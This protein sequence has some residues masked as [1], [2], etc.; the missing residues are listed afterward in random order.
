MPPSLVQ[1]L[2]R[3]MGRGAVLAS[4]EDLLVYECD[5]LS[6]FRERAEAIVFPRSTEEVSRIVTLCAE[7]SVP[8]VPRGA[9]TGLSGGATPVAGGVVVELARMNQILRVVEEDRC[10][11]VECGV[12]NA[13]LSAAVRPHGLLYAPDPSSQFACTIGGNVAENSGGPH[14][15]KYGQTAR[16]VLGLTLVLCDGS[17]V[18]AGGPDGD[19]PGYDLAGAFTGSEGTFGIATEAWV[20]LEPIPP[21]VETFLASFRSIV[22]A[23][24]AVSGIVAEGIVP[25]ALEMLDERTIAA[26]E[27]SVYAA[28][29]PREAAAV[30]LVELDGAAE[31]VH[32]DAQI[33]RAVCRRCGAIDLTEAVEEAERLR[34]WK[35]RKSAFG[36]MGRVAPDLYVLDA[37]VPR[38]RL[39]EVVAKVCEIGDRHRL[40]LANLLH[41]GDGNLHPNIALD[42]R[43]PDE[44]ARV[45]AAGD[46]ILRACVEAGGSLTGEHGV[47]LEKRDFMACAFTEADLA[48][49]RRLREAFDSAGLFNPGKALPVRG[50]KEA[51]AAR[52]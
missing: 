10:A 39:P 18:R 32:A 11:H 45:L 41:A 29:Y 14:C 44:V 47:G 7:R 12:V 30:L 9:G 51:G 20:R 19:V 16:H 21:F 31:Q 43:D 5:A 24:R 3:M 26:V 36:A 17:I 52:R 49:M 33:V 23:C 35:G 50:C 6:L 2:E 46:E 28:G 38:A 27:S 25:A 22:D 8:V 1:D 4:P 40:R 42:A 37:V 34:L 15:L 13:D 48:P